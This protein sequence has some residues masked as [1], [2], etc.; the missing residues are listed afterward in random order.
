MFA[1]NFEWPNH[2]ELL[3]NHRKNCTVRLGD[4][5]DIYPEN[6]LVWITFGKKYSPRRKLFWRLLIGHILKNF[7]S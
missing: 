1:L 5:R 6:S 2:E 4:S 7:P 3:L